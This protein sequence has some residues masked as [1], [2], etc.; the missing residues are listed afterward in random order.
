MKGTYT[1]YAKSTQGIEWEG[2][3]EVLGGGQKNIPLRIKDKED[4]IH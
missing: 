1:Y 3:Y 4:A 2:T